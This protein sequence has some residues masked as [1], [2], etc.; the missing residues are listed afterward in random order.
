MKMNMKKAFE[1]E[2]KNL[3]KT[4]KFGKPKNRKILKKCLT[5]PNLYSILAKRVAGE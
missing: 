5:S 3:E 4:E 1:L 2:E